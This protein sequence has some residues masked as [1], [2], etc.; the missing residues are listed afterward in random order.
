MI[1]VTVPVAYHN[2]IQCHT[3]ITQC[4]IESYKHYTVSHRIRCSVIQHHTVLVLLPYPG[5]GTPDGVG[6]QLPR[7]PVL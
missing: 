1:L 3:N 7:L 2:V 4:H 6:A 5:G